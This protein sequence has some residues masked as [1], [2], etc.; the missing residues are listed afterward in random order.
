MKVGD[1]VELSMERWRLF[2]KEEYRDI[3]KVGVVVHAWSRSSA[4]IE[5]YRDID[6]VGVVVHTWNP[7]V[8]T[9]QWSTGRETVELR[10]HIR[11]FKGVR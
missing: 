7:F 5:E 9:V 1:L 2:K 6:K 11:R 4:D 3:D 8:V 10:E